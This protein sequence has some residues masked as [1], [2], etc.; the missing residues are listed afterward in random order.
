LS[1][2]TASA[3]SPALVTTALTGKDRDPGDPARKKFRTASLDP[4]HNPAP[5]V[6]VRKTVR[7]QRQ[8]QPSPSF[9][10]SSHASADRVAPLLC[11]GAPDDFQFGLAIHLGC[12]AGEP[13]DAQNNMAGASVHLRSPVSG[14]TLSDR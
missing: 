3:C 5:H 7:R 1:K 14:D 13:V 4:E 6:A 12:M 10:R 2:A 9:S 11:K 8:D